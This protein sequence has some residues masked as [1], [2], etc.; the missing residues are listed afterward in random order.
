MARVL[1]GAGTRDGEKLDVNIRDSVGKMV[2]T[3]K[4]APIPPN[5]TMLEIMLLNAAEISCPISMCFPVLKI[6]RN[7]EIIPKPLETAARKPS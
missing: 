1:G 7:P 4:L 5:Y 3:W 2:K 6:R